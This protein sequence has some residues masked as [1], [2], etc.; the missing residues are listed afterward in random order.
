MIT[1]RPLLFT[2]DPGLRGCGIAYFG[3]DGTLLHAKYLKNPVKKGGGPEAWL[4]FMDELQEQNTQGK[5]PL[6]VQTFVS[7]YPQVYRAGTSKGDPDDL[8]QLA[9]VVATFASNIV[10]KDYLAVRPRE[11]KGTVPKDV[12]HARVLKALDDHE[13]LIVEA[14]APPSLRHNVFDAVGIGLW[15]L[16]KQGIRGA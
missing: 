16:K 1:T 15:W 6:V 4:G 11:W 7:E 9:S 14:S 12:H 10:A 13:K 5:L 3:D 8:L 2:L